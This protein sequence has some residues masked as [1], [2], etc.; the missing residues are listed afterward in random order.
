MAVKVTLGHFTALPPTARP[1]VLR[2][3]SAQSWDFTLLAGRVPEVCEVFHEKAISKGHPVP[4]AARD[5]VRR[6]TIEVRKLPWS[7][8]YSGHGEG[9]LA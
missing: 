7:Y 2:T 4:K 1:L 8:E 9:M 6:I 5:D 3:P